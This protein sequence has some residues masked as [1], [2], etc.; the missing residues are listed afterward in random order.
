[1]IELCPRRN[2]ADLDIECAG[3]GLGVV[4]GNDERSGRTRARDVDLRRI[5]EIRSN[6][7][8][9]GEGSTEDVD[10]RLARGD[11]DRS[12]PCDRSIVAAGGR[13]PRDGSA[14][15]VQLPIADQPSFGAAQR[16]RRG[17]DLRLRECDIPEAHLGEPARPGVAQSLGIE[18]IADGQGVAVITDRGGGRARGDQRSIEIELESGRVV[19]ERNAIPGV[20]NRCPVVGNRNASRC[21]ADGGPQCPALVPDDVGILNAGADRLSQNVTHVRGEVVAGID[22]GF[23]RQCGGRA[24]NGGVGNLDVVVHAVEEERRRDR[25]RR[26]RCNPG[27]LEAWGSAQ[28]RVV[29]IGRGIARHDARPV[30]EAPIA[31]EAGLVAHEGGAH[32][33]L[34]VGD[35]ARDAPEP[36]IADFPRPKTTQLIEVV[37]AADDQRMAV[38]IER[39]G[40]C[41]GGDQGAIDIELQTGRVVA[42]RDVVPGVGRRAPG[43][44]DLRAAGRVA[45][46][47]VELAARI[48]D[49]VG[50][51]DAGA[52]R[53]GHQDTG[54]RAEI[55]SQRCP[56]LHR[57]GIGRAQRRSVCNLDIVANTVEGQPGIGGPGGLARYDAA[58]ISGVAVPRDI[59]DGRSG[60]LEIPE[61]IEAALAAG[62]TAIHIG[63]ERVRRARDVPDADVVDA[64]LK[65]VVPSR[66]LADPERAGGI[67]DAARVIGPLG[68]EH[69]IDVQ[70]HEVAGCADHRIEVIPLPGLDEARRRRDIER[71][72]ADAALRRR[73]EIEIAG[74]VEPECVF[75]VRS[76]AHRIGAVALEEYVLPGPWEAVRLEPA[77]DGQVR[78][79]MQRRT[80]GHLDEIVAVETQAVADRPRIP[81]HAPPEVDSAAGLGELAAQPE[82]AAAADR[83][84]TGIGEIADRR[85]IVAIA[86]RQA[87]A[88]RIGGQTGERPGR[89]IIAVEI[90][91][92]TVDEDRRGIDGDGLRQGQTQ[93]RTVEHLPCA[94][95]QRGVGEIGDGG[96]DDAD[97]LPCHI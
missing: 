85:E 9:A 41:V 58:E 3:R 1:M 22:P 83:Q 49:G 7:T 81:D 5:G 80:V 24:Q 82:R 88:G 76:A 77:A 55:G 75:A 90:R 12:G 93:G 15:L 86:D 13:I 57:Q 96:R 95:G 74:R 89:A 25:R 40:G 92:G 50:I 63:P 72:H 29:S 61:R 16:L 52:D 20:W 54:A 43:E 36:R 60:T 26:I 8:A 71:A 64:A 68:R 35:A 91:V 17:Q 59:A 94:A 56:D 48:P 65:G 4:A 67:A 21:I 19:G 70:P 84:R 23:D 27:R 42:E 31:G 51:I 53:L 33:S 18:V 14:A 87:A 73:G 6:D 11:P 10:R 78:R 47:G 28:K 66:R 30:V 34:D 45:G 2:A 37:V 46:T 32:V 44:I 97:P 79:G 69:P 39:R 38:I 62:E